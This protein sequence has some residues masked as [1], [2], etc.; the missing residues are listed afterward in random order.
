MS[1]FNLRAIQ[2]TLADLKIDGWLFYDFQGSDPI[3]RTILQVPHETAQ[4]HRWYYFIPKEGAPVKIVHSIE[5]GI[6]DHLPG[7]KQV[8]VGWR[9]LEDKLNFSVGKSSLIAAQYSSENAIPNISRL[10][11]GTF[12]LL[13]R[14][15]ITIVS[16]GELIQLFESRWSEGQLNTHLNTAKH[17][18]EIVQKSFRLIKRKINGHQ[19]ITELSLQKWIMLELDKRGLCSD[20]PPII[21]SGSNSGNPHYLPTEQQNSPML[22]G[23]VVLLNL[24]AKERS[25]SAV[26]A[27]ITWMGYVGKAVPDKFQALFSLICQ[28]RDRTI[29]H[30]RTAIKAKKPLLGFQVDDFARKMLKEAGYGS[31]FLHRTGHSLGRT[32]NAYGANMD[33]LETYD[34]RPLVSHTCFSIE[35]ALYFSDF[36]LRSEV[37]VFVRKQDIQITTQPV[38]TEIVPIMK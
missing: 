17:L 7:K 25:A 26:Y 18:H 12:E 16:S 1:G 23:D 22:P 29:E 4:T 34:E 24:W 35:P 10:D 3:G 2:K 36:G 21:A 28:T 30:I 19:E 31:Y 11:A 15:K 13:Q 33:N 38:Q 9:E 5:R 37:N 14:L 32:I 20:L 6:L 27:V 8:Y